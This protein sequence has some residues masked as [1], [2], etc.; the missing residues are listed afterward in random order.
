MF[1]ELSQPLRGRAIPWNMYVY[2]YTHTYHGIDPVSNYIYG[3][4]VSENR[5]PLN[6]VVTYHVSCSNSHEGD[7]YINIYRPFLRLH[8]FSDTPKFIETIG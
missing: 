7:I 4:T 5:L 8:H 3:F 2:I 6:P 1:P